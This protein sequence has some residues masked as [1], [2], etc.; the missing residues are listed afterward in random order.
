[1]TT[2]LCFSEY[3][4]YPAT[5]VD[6]WTAI[7][8]LA[9]KWTFKSV[10]VLAIKSLSSIASPVDKIILGRKYDIEEWLSDAYEAVCRRPEPLT[11]E[12]GI[13]LQMDDVIKIYAIRHNHGITRDAFGPPVVTLLSD[14][15]QR[16]DLAEW[17]AEKEALKKQQTMRG[18][19][20]KLEEERKQ[21]I[22]LKQEAKVRAEAEL[23][24]ELSDAADA[25]AAAAKGLDLSML[26]PKERKSRNAQLENVAVDVKE[27]SKPKH[28]LG[29]KSIDFSRFA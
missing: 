13:R 23:E 19:Q 1:M 10:R 22:Q 5:T 28:K 20:E 27:L 21:R 3:G 29:P 15:R 25:A 11:L 24:K 12:E 26:S 16:F 18:C 9:D 7:M 6:E 17:R 14:V 4:I 8:H 2:N